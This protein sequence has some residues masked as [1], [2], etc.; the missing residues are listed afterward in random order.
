MTSRK[1][2]LLTLTFLAVF[3]FTLGV[4]CLFKVNVPVEEILKQK[5]VS[6]FLINIVMSTI[7]LVYAVIVITMTVVFHR[8]L[9]FNAQRFKIAVGTLLLLA[10]M[11]GSFFALLITNNELVATFKGYQQKK[12]NKFMIGP[13]PEEERL[14]LLKKEGYQGVI[15]LLSPT[16]PFEKILLEREKQ[17]GEK[18]GLNIYS[19]PMLPWIS[20]NEKSLKGIKEL[21]EKEK[22]PFYIHCYLGKHRA[23]LVLTTITGEIKTYLYPD[24][25]EN[26]RLY[27]YQDGRIILG[28]FPD[29]E[30]WFHLV[31]RGQV[32]EVISF[33]DPDISEEALLIEK[34]KN[35]CAESGVELK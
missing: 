30:E 29:D 33:L 34:E 5:N 28:P 19:F 6:Q 9:A 20:G 1:S 15:S 25:L 35:I 24:V 12:D 8:L 21:V 31:K 17:A 10:I 11:S 18:I 23:D 3:G 22:G 14:H 16:I 26:G 2:W 27:Y 13:Y 4:V 32:K 7:I